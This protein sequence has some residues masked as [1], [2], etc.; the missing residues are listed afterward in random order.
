M[1]L[2]SLALS[3]LCSAALVWSAA[4]PVLFFGAGVLLFVGTVVLEGTA[5]SLVRSRAL[6][7]EHSTAAKHGLPLPAGGGAATEVA[8]CMQRWAM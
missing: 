7:K 5:T 4:S 3:G 8:R 2:A 1:V 6:Q